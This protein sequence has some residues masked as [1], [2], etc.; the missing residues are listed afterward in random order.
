[1]LTVRGGTAQRALH[2]ILDAAGRG[3]DPAGPELRLDVAAGLVHLPDQVVPVVL[4]SPGPGEVGI[5]QD[6]LVDRAFADVAGEATVL[7]ELGDVRVTTVED[8]RQVLGAAALAR[9]AGV[10]AAA[11]RAGVRACGPPPP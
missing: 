6:L 9:A 11:V 5:V 1:M 8:L 10:S 7:A 3:H 2:A 4:H